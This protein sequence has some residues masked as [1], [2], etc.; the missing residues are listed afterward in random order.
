MS[1]PFLNHFQCG[2]PHCLHIKSNTLVWVK[3]S[4]SWFNPLIPFKCQC[5]LQSCMFPPPPKFLLYILWGH[6]LNIKTWKAWLIQFRFICFW[7]LKKGHY[8]SELQA[9]LDPA[10]QQFPQGLNF[11]STDYHGPKM[12]A[13]NSWALC[14]FV[15][16]SKEKQNVFAPAFLI[17]LQSDCCSVSSDF[18]WLPEQ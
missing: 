11:F 8:L 17:H 5:L 18:L 6:L 4:P 13:S 7:V 1:P 2:S 9:G 12:I 16:V 14:F 15:H 3:E 10:A